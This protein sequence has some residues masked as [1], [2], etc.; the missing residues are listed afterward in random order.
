VSRV[1]SARPR[2]LAIGSSYPPHSFGGYELVWQS[3]MRWLIDRGYRVRI[4]ASDLRLEGVGAKEDPDV[5]RQLSWYWRDHEFPPIGQVAR[6]RLER[7]NRR[8]L[9]E[10]LEDFRPDV[11]MWWAMGGMS[12]S[13]IELVR[14]AG[15]P[16]IGYV[17]DDW[18]DYGPTVD[19]WTRAW[20]QRGWLGRLVGALSGI[21]TRFDPGAAGSWHFNSERTRVHAREIGRDLPRTAVTPSGI[22]TDLFQPRPAGDWGWRLLYLGRIDPRKGIATAIEATARLQSE[23]T[24]RIVGDG[25]PAGSGFRSSQPGRASRCPKS[26]RR[27][28]PCFFRSSGR[29]HGGSCHWRRWRLDGRWSRPEP[30]DRANTCG[31]E[32]TACCSHRAIPKRSPRRLED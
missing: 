16:S 5:Y 17:G 10:H 4:L 2:V 7:H 26:T 29:S 12:L 8:V 9:R 20:V 21:P 27:P 24:L 23:A 18:M 28:M 13:M 30:E 25:D 15:L 19:A 3:A 32:R 1:A 11:V 31:M 22:D 14:R 6:L